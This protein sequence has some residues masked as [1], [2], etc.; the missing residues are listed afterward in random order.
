MD[1]NQFAEA[2]AAASVARINDDQLYASIGAYDPEAVKSYK[3]LKHKEYRAIAL[4]YYS[5][6]E[7]QFHM[8]RVIDGKTPVALSH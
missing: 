3:E 6:D 8:Q 4:K 7:S 1:K 2:Y 5:D